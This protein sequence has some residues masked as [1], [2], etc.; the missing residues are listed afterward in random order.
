MAETDVQLAQTLEGI[1]DLKGNLVV[2]KLERGGN[3]IVHRSSAD[4]PAFVYYL[5]MEKDNVPASEL[6]KPRII[7][8]DQVTRDLPPTTLIAQD[9]Y[10]SV[11]NLI[12]ALEQR[13]D[14]NSRTAAASLKSLTFA[15]LL[16][17]N[18]DI[19]QE[20]AE[21]GGLADLPENVFLQKVID[22]HVEGT[23]LSTKEFAAARLT[24]AL[25][26][27]KFQKKQT[28]GK[29]YSGYDVNMTLIPIDTLPLPG[30]QRFDDITGNSI[31]RTK[32]STSRL[33]PGSIDQALIDTKLAY[34]FFERDG[35]VIKTRMGCTASLYEGLGPR[36][37]SRVSKS[38]QRIF[39]PL[40]FLDQR[41]VPLDT[42]PQGANRCSPVGAM[43]AFGI[44][45]REA[46]K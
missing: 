25:V 28:L 13:Q 42:Y 4:A 34:P 39:E 46:V 8:V 19:A 1:Q 22:R 36:K 9:R 43:Q 44:R 45:F 7:Q 33:D 31:M 40:R 24:D 16:N 41:E 38:L 29:S 12:K 2:E 27:F 6:R 32:F 20:F 21:A 14:E 35:D 26:A 17:T 3:I 23:S 18:R 11:Y 15:Q 30:K 5:P 37:D 10:E